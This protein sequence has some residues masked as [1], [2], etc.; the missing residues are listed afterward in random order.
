M[1]WLLLLRLGIV[2]GVFLLGWAMR[3][4]TVPL[5]AAYLLMLICLPWRQR[6]KRKIG[7]TPATLTCMLGLVVIPTLFLLPILTE[8]DNLVTL[9]P[10]L[11]NAP[12][13]TEKH[14]QQPLHKLIEKLPESLQQELQGIEKNEVIKK[15]GQYILQLL[16]SIKGS[17]MAFLGGTF[18]IFSAILLMPIF[19]FYLLN[20]APWLPRFRGELPKSWRPRFDRTVPRIQKLLRVYCRARLTVAAGKGAIA[21]VILLIFGIPG[22]YTLG[23]MVGVFSLLPVVGALVSAVALLVVSVTVHGSMGLVLALS[24]YA[25]TEV[26]EGYVLLPRLVGREL[27]MSDFVVIL[28]VLGGGALMGF[29]G[30]L[31]AI[32]A[33]A[34]GK[35]LYDEFVRPLMQDP[36]EVEAV[37]ESATESGA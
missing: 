3:T 20:G 37:P 6:L 17:I 16:G 22:A 9:L 31:I 32:P 30:L 8:M 5:L 13:W 36:D 27:G 12:Q 18:G 7:G 11:E 4:V 24:V 33:V 28:A 29:F 35:V 25:I 23:L 21:W 10:S 34:I 26:I 15:S 1:N 19:L 2:A 14:V